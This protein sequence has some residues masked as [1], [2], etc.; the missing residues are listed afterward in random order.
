MNYLKVT[1][2]ILVLF[3]SNAYSAS[4]ESRCRDFFLDV[5]EED[6]SPHEQQLV[7]GVANLMQGETKI[8]LLNKLLEQS[9]SSEV[10]YDVFNSLRR[11][12]ASSKQRRDALLERIK[13]NSSSDS[14]K[15][16][17]VFAASSFKGRTR[18]LLLNELLKLDLSSKALHTV[19][20]GF[21]VPMGGKSGVHVLKKVLEKEPSLPMVK[22]VSRA[23]VNIGGKPGINF[24]KNLLEGLVLESFEEMKEIIRSMDIKFRN[25]AEIHFFKDM[26]KQNILPEVRNVI[27][28]RIAFTAQSHRSEGG[29]FLVKELLENDPSPEELRIIVRP[30]HPG[31][32]Q[33]TYRRAEDYFG[34]LLEMNPSLEVIEVIVNFANEKPAVKSSL[35]AWIPDLAMQGKALVSVNHLKNL[36][37]IE[38]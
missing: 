2:S 7:A 3:I 25:P 23:L 27:V 20:S 10:F 37:E 12:K 16:N 18:T 13:I 31:I 29:L 35:R 38:I 6:L 9:S 30:I 34:R 19:I 4:L 8:H 24:F 11:D 32:G 15:E 1:V 36:L 17:L 28:A 22:A 26:L 21:A 14:E 33:T 5:L